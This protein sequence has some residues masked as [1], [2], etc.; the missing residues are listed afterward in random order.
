MVIRICQFTG[1]EQLGQIHVSSSYIR[2]FATLCADMHNN[3]LA[4]NIEQVVIILFL[5]CNIF[6]SQALL[7][8]CR[9]LN[10]GC[11]DMD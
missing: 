5:L 2:N 10:K 7:S 8:N 9:F 11:L 1:M 6:V 4:L 3:S